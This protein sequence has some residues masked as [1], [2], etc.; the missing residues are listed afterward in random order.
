[1]VNEKDSFLQA[2]ISP[3]FQHPILNVLLKLTKRLLKLVIDI[4]NGIHQGAS[5]IKSSS[6]RV[7]SSNGKWT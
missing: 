4:S 2:L 6:F 1:M 7:E 5:P 3:Q